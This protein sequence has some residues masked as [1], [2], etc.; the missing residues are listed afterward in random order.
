M[1]LMPIFAFLNSTSSEACAF[2]PAA[3]REGFVDGQNVG[4]RESW[5]DGS[6][7]RPPKL[8]AEMA[9]SYTFVIAAHGKVGA[10]Q[11]EA[12]S[13]IVLRATIQA[14]LTRPDNLA[15]STIL[16]MYLTGEFVMAGNLTSNVAGIAWMYRQ[17]GRGYQQGPATPDCDR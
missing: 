17:D 15:R 5:A 4:M 14:L 11:S 12:L 10:K 13:E 16:L 1:M 3:F 6:N 9:K 8:A 2:T 7:D